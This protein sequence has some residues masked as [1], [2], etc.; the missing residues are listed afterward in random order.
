MIRNAAFDPFARKNGYPTTDGKPMAETDHHRT[1]MFDV[2][3]TL[4]WWFAHD[5]FVYVSGNL[6]VCYEEGNKRKHVSPDAFLVKGIPRGKRPNLLLWEEGGHLDVV[7]EIT[8]R[9]TRAEDTKK[10]YELYRDALGVREYF[11]FDPYEEYLNPTLQG[12]KRVG[13]GFRPIRPVNGRLPSRILGLHLER[14]RNDLRFWNPDTEKWLVAPMEHASV[15]EAERQ[16]RKAAEAE[17]ERLRRENEELRRK[18]GG[19]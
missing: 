11:L 17:I 15:A 2:I 16:A 14:D 19:G 18:L 3:G 13:E 6:I 1:V 8:S 7:I 4:A 12:H 10:K 5:P 9:T